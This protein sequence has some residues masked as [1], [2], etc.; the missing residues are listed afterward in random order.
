MLPGNYGLKDQL[1][2]MRWV[3]QNIAQF[4]GDPGAVT[5]YGYSA[6]AGS[7][8]LHMLSPLSEGENNNIL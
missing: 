3:K 4:G 1:L 5:L 2:V 8:H 7:A 6:G